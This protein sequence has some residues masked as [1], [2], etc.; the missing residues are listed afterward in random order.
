VKTIPPLLGA[1]LLLSLASATALAAPAAVEQPLMQVF[2]G[3]AELDDQTATWQDEAGETVD[4]NFDSLP[5]G[6]IELEYVFGRGFVH[7]GLNPGG[8]VAWK[9]D[10]T[11]VAGRLTEQNGGTF[12]V[13]FDNSLLLTELHLGAYVRGRLNE[14]VTTYAAA[15][16]MVMYGSLDVDNDDAS[17]S[18]ADDDSGN[19]DSSSS[20][21]NIGY[22]G[23]AGI[24]FALDDKQQLGLGVRYLSSDLDFDKTIGNVDIEG[25]QYVLTFTVQL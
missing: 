6:G 13:S 1:T 19:N 7:W 8:S 5:V 20:D 17:A 3:V 10:N 15:G 11:K 25:P 23:R 16:P 4:V 14:R 2:L 18:Q 24:D 9:E 12:L 21:V 22:Y